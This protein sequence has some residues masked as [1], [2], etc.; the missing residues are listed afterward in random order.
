G[1]ISMHG[2]FNSSQ[3]VMKH[4]CNFEAKKCRKTQVILG[5][6]FSLSTL[7]SSINLPPF[8]IPPF[9]P[10]MLGPAL[11]SIY[12]HD[13]SL[14]LCICVSADYICQAANY[15]DDADAQA[16]TNSNECL[17]YLTLSIIPMLASRTSYGPSLASLLNGYLAPMSPDASYAY[18]SYES[19]NVFT[20]HRDNEPVADTYETTANNLHDKKVPKDYK[21]LVI[22]KSVVS[23]SVE[24]VGNMGTS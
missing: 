18:S 10:K 22:N 15:L 6:I 11:T 14:C 24:V 3:I 5:T 4:W 21:P 2:K 1:L 19:L 20:I 13:G 12:V 9:I 16:I 7:V 17:G 8:S 23:D